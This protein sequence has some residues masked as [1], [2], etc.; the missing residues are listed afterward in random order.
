[1]PETTVTTPYATAMPYVSGTLQTWLGEYD[2]QR[3][4]S[5][6]LYD[7]LFNNMPDTAV[8]MLRGSDETPI[9]LP[10]A[11]RLINTLARYV[12]KDWRY[13]AEQA[14][15]DDAG[16][17]VTVDAEDF[18]NAVR[19]LENLWRRERLLAQFSSGKK[20]FLR[21]GDWV[22]MISADPEKPEGRR[23]SVKEIDPRTYFPVQD[24][25]SDLSRVTG[26]QIIEEI[27]L[28]D[29]ET[30]AVKVQTWIKTGHQEYEDSWAGD[31]GYQS[32]TYDTE[33]FS[34]VSKRKLLTTDVPLDVLPGI[35]A[36]PLYHIKNNEIGAD[37]YGRSDLSGIESVIAG[38][39]QAVSDEDLALAISGLGMY[40]TDGGAPVDE[41]TGETSNWRL[42]PQ[43]VIEVASG[44]KFA[45]VEGISSV[46]PSQTH[47]K[48]LQ[49][50]AYGV[51]GV[52]DV[53]MGTATQVEAGISL[54]LK[55]SPVFD[56]ADEKD[57]AING[58]FTQLLHDLRDWFNVFEGVDMSFLNLTSVTS[59]DDRMPFDR[60]A[61]FTELMALFQA[62]LVSIQFVHNELNARFGYNLSAD[63][64]KAAMESLAAKTAA[65]DAYAERGNAE[66]DAELDTAGAGDTTQE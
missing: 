38:I 33:D 2:A 59:Q 58:V 22:W 60:D 7:D 21:R 66:L 31:I 14:T 9:Y 45:R 51:N 40:W 44:G 28:P 34:D 43:E 41:E 16:D 55:L 11:K 19:K 29:N 24:D 5:Y 15:V 48:F 1:M 37:P 23:I 6:D 20:G 12:G 35:K 61:R 18:D 30:A 53:A 57:L 50:E 3:L 49:S 17:P 64:A 46:E 13:L 52:S 39:N 56:A 26:C 10:T 25:E 62:N 4:A 63:E 32:E 36:L 8:L 47:I 65:G 54:A 42:G 27:L